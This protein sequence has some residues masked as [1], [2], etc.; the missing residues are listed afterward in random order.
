[1]HHSQYF[2]MFMRPNKFGLI[3]C[4]EVIE[5]CFGFKNMFRLNKPLKFAVLAL[6]GDFPLKSE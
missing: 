5:N 4:K 3:A 1:M 6:F 2:W